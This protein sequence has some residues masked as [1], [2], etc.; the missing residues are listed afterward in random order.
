MPPTDAAPPPWSGALVRFGEIGIKSAPVRRAM[1][2]RLRQNLLDGLVRS[3]VEGDVRAMGSR[4]WMVGPDVD[5]LAGV[6]CR[7]FGV[8][9]V[10]PCV[11]KKGVLPQKKDKDPGWRPTALFDVD[12]FQKLIR[13][14]TVLSG[15]ERLVGT[16]RRQQAPRPRP[17]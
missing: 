17:R 10:S 3:G 13:D 15:I 5:A 14:E 11:L 9:S 12:E 16:L 1:V 7:T 2:E 4:L 8:V 6:A